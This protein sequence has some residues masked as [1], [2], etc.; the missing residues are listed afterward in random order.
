V[1]HYHA[2]GFS[3]FAIESKSAADGERLSQAYNIIHELTPTIRSTA[4]DK[5]DGV[6]LSKDQDSTQLTM[7]D[8]KLT[9]K[10]DYTLSWA[11]KPADG[12]WPLTGG[13]IISIANDEFYIAGTGLVVTFKPLI[14]DKRAGLVR[15]DEGTFMNGKWSPGRR[16]NGDED[17]QGRHVSIPASSLEIQRV[18]LYTY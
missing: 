15:V 13:I 12:R 9:V 6:L 18:K 1:G 16:L 14:N 10:H 8:Y 7:G 17:H 4:T 3:P 2:L 5:V 11:P